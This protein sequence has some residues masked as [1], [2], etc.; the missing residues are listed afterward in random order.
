MAR[1]RLL[2]NDQASPEAKKIYEKLEQNGAKI[3]NLYRALAHSPSVMVD[4]MKLGNSLLSKTKLSS[5]LR[6][7]VILRIAGLSGSKYEWT[8]HRP[9]ALEAGV[10]GDQI[11][12]LD[13]WRQSKQFTDE[14]A[15][16]VNVKEE[17]FN[18]L[19]RFLTEQEIVELT[20]AIG[21]WGLI[22][23]VLVPLQ[24]DLFH[25]DGHCSDNIE[26]RCFFVEMMVWR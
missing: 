17:T 7:L 15:Q 20:L 25:R 8:Q 23:R 14:L 16:V 3:L 22:A 9:V 12:A 2:S 13:G 1:V 26:A 11:G 4:C 21:Y 18:A 10:T 5:K 19:K 24:V 6:E